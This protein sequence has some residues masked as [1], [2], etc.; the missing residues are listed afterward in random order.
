M[1]GQ[2][3]SSSFDANSSVQYIVVEQIKLLF[4]P[5]PAKA[6][7]K[8]VIFLLITMPRG[9]FAVKKGECCWGIVSGHDDFGR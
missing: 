3:A 4:S 1:A 9:L 2:G 7:A 5:F 6:E 8:V